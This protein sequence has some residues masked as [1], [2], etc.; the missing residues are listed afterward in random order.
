MKRQIIGPKACNVIAR[1]VAKRR[2]GLLDD[3]IIFLAL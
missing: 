1:A 2:P 3:G